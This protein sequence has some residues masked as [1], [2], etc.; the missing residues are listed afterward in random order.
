MEFRPSVTSGLVPGHHTGQLGTFLTG[1]QSFS[2][3]VGGAAPHLLP[4]RAW[5]GQ[6]VPA[7]PPTPW[8]SR[9]AP[10]SSRCCSPAVS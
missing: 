4:A 3:F 9:T 1:S 7:P 2:D 6:P 10:R 8:A 5:T